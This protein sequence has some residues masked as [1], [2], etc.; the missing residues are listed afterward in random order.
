MFFCFFFNQA[1]CSRQW[2]LRKRCLCF[3]ICTL[4]SIS[5]FKLIAF[6]IGKIQL[7]LRFFF[8]FFFCVSWQD[9]SDD[10]K[11]ALDAVSFSHRVLVIRLHHTW[12]GHL[13]WIFINLFCLFPSNLCQN[14][15]RQAAKLWLH[16]HEWSLYMGLLWYWVVWRRNTF[17]IFRFNLFSA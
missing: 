12:L 13:N 16:C 8:I 6:F 15:G 2:N 5:V 14:L 1:R 17:S 9:I 10:P 11:Q 3:I 7:S 4:L